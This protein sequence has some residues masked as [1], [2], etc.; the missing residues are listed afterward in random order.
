VGPDGDVRF[1]LKLG[2]W[3]RHDGVVLDQD[4]CYVAVQS[5]DR[6]FDGWFVTAVRTTGI[7]CRPSCP[8][9]TPKR[10]N[11][12][13]FPTAAAAQQRGFRA[14]KRCR[15]D[16]SP[17]SPEWNV[18]QDVVGRAMRLIADGCIEREGVPGLARRL[19]YS[20]RQLNRLMTE[21]LG[22]GPLAVARA[23]RAHTA[24]LLIETTDMALTDIAFAAGFGSVRQFNDTIREVFAT[25]PT[26]LR[27]SRTARRPSSSS[28]EE[29]MASGAM[30]GSV[31]LRLPTRQPFAGDDVL[32]FLGQRT[33]AGIESWDGATYRRALRLPNG[34]GVVTLRAMSDHVAADVRLESWSDLGAAVQRIRR[35]LDLDA[36]PE[37]IDAA[38]STEPIMAALVD[39][40]PGR[41]SPGSTDPF[42]T[43]IRAIVGQ[44]V[45]VAG[46]R[47]VTSKL[48]E[49]V[50]D[51]LSLADAELTHVFPS[52]VRFAEADDAAFAM[53]G[54]R[55]ATL[56][57]FAVAVADRTVTLG[58]GAD[59]D[60]ARASLL[61]LKGVGPWT[62]DYIVMR[63]LSHPDVFL[64]SDLGVRHAIDRLTDSPPD[65]SCWAP[66]R[67]YAIHHLW[68]DL[69]AHTGASA[70][71]V[72]TKPL[73]EPAS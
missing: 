9:I 34:H 25:A 44:Q 35:L 45:S 37:A 47:T 63:G 33:L 54:S 49:A 67:S 61:D 28:A 1:P 65:P 52:A 30:V 73:E 10:S 12:D 56:R 6:R 14:C 46:A 32:A 39:S 27:T 64:G 19:G 41:R 58:P 36:D 13:F 66:W 68:A 59:P 69:T 20:E 72:L 8:A 5:R 11:V 3:V 48:I 24:R 17:G 15:P 21:E 70:S 31:S 51:R 60:V 55:R 16:A 42:E 22:A 40:T 71:P 4:Q 53:P 57:R 23:Q 62:A 43:G 26:D 38:L 50:G 7:Y 18:R 29:G 2:G